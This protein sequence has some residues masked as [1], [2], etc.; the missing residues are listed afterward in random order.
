MGKGETSSFEQVFS[1]VQTAAE[2]TDLEHEALTR[3]GQPERSIKVTVP[4]RRDDG[5]LELLAGY[6]VQHNNLR[7]PYKGGVRF[8]PA[9]NVEELNQL[10]LWMTLKCAVADVPFGGA[11]G[12]VSVDTADLSPFE[13]ERLSRNYIRQLDAEIG[14]HTDIPA[15]DVATNEKVMGWM[16]DEYSR[17]H[18]CRTPGSITGKPVAVGGSRGRKD[19][20][21]W[22]GALCVE[23]WIR[24]EN[25]EFDGIRVAVQGFGNVG[26]HFARIV[27][28]RGLRV[29]AVSDSSTGVFCPEGL[30]VEELLAGKQ[31]GCRLD[32]LIERE[33]LD[34]WGKGG[35]TRSMGHDELLEL[36]VDVLAP[37]ALGGVIGG[38][39][40]E[41]VQAR[42]IVELAN[43]P[44]R[45]DADDVLEGKGIRV[46]PDILANSGGVTASYF[47]WLQNREG[48]QWSEQRCYEELERSMRE[49]CGSV[50][51]RSEELDIP[52]RKAAYVVAL[53][54]IAA[55]V[56]AMGTESY[57][58]NGQEQTGRECS[59]STKPLKP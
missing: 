27:A 51:K 52:L 5:S 44:I 45:P 28:Q 20:T 13:L 54:R 21:A 22:G 12:G 10:A 18:Q 32:A 43:G 30:H 24:R 36:D 46:L 17:L 41:R 1:R 2:E 49:A 59:S 55:A 56:S 15:P 14:P 16:M 23:E 53:E 11:K 4:V 42:Q 3:L 48:R 26:G 31:S 39:N 40:A 33:G 38:R 19:A 47:E 50:W 6:R 29:V 37:A 58:N 25:R 7:G 34:R 35:E 9:V 8:H 57:Y